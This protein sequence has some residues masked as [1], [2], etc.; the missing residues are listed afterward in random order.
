MVMSLAVI[1]CNYSICVSIDKFKFEKKL[2][3]I[4]VHSDELE[5]RQKSTLANFI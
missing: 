3:Q 5:F 1:F 4:L 2:I